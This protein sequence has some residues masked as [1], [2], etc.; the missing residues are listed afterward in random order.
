MPTTQNTGEC[1]HISGF[2]GTKQQCNSHPLGQVASSSQECCCFFLVRMPCPFLGRMSP[3][4]HHSGPTAR[5]SAVKPWTS[6]SPSTHETVQHSQGT[7]NTTKTLPT[8]PQTRS[9]HRKYSPTQVGAPSPRTELPNLGLQT[10]LRAGPRRRRAR[11]HEGQE[12]ED[13]AARLRGRPHRRASVPAPGAARRTSTK[14]S[15]A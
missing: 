1:T 4:R 5:S 13:L 11:G 8:T 10:V 15:T 2:C 14:C 3:A 7:L 12:G 6:T 9:K